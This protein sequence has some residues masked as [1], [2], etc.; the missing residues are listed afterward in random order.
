VSGGHR[1]A[2]LLRERMFDSILAFVT[3]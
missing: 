3:P 1:Y 2:Y